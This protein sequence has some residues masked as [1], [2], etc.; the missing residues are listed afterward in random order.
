MAAGLLFSTHHHIHHHSNGNASTTMLTENTPPLYIY[1]YE[2]E[3][4]TSQPP[5]PVAY[6]KDTAKLTGCLMS[7]WP[8]TG[9]QPPQYGG[10]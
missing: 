10:V 2:V 5:I 1:I 8:S 9:P 3:A 7:D 4:K 6:K